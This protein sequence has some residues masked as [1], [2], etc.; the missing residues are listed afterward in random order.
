MINFAV[1][2]KRIKKLNFWM[3]RKSHFTLFVVGSVIVLVL[4]FNEDTSMKLNLQYQDQIKELKTQ[5]KECN[6]SAEW[7]RSR[8]EALYIDREN[9]EHVVRE[10]Y[11]LQRPTEDVY[12]IK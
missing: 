12:L 2:S 6:D 7:Y 4:F 10:Q 8:R 3:R 11:H 9:L 1:M 5:I